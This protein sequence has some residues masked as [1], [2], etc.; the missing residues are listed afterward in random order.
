LKSPKRIQTG[1][2]GGRK[3]VSYFVN[4]LIF[5]L[6]MAGIFC[7][8]QSSHCRR[9]TVAFRKEQVVTF[10]LFPPYFP[11]ICAFGYSFALFSPVGP[12]VSF[13]PFLFDVL[14]EIFK[15]FASQTLDDSLALSC[16]FSVSIMFYIFSGCGVSTLSTRLFICA[17]FVEIVAV[18]IDSQAGL[19]CPLPPF[20]F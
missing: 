14:L 13:S 2:F 7:Y 18:F 4:L 15:P 19:K 16:N 3:S 1:F 17:S 9:A 12:A 11:Q 5:P 20:F 8:L 10:A 6:F